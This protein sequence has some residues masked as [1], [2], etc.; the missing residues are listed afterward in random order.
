[1][2]NNQDISQDNYPI[3]QLRGK[4][5]GMIFQEPMTSL[6]PL[7]TI[8]KQISEAIII[9]NPDED[10]NSKIKEL[11]SM[12]EL[13]Y[14]EERINSFPH[15]LSGGERQRVMLA[16][17]IANKPKLLIADEP[18]TA[19]DP[20]TQK[21]ILAL[22]NKLRRQF[23]MSVLL[24]SH[25]I[26]LVKQ[27]SDYIYIIFQGKIIEHNKSYNIFNDPQNDYTKLLINPFKTTRNENKNS[28]SQDL[29]KISNL[30]I[31]LSNTKSFL[32]KNYKTI[33]H[34]INLTLN[35]SDILGIIGKSGS[36]KTTL[37]NSI[38]GLNKGSGEII[39][40]NQNILKNRNH[41]GKIQIVFQD[42]YSSL[43]PKMTIKEIIIE[44]L[45]INKKK[46]EIN[47]IYDTLKMVDLNLEILDKYPHALSG[48]QKQRV[49]IARAIITEPEILI[50]DEATSSLDQITQ[51]SII[52]LLNKL[53]Q[54]KNISMIFITHNIDLLSRLCNKVIVM[55]K[56][57]IIEYGNTAEII[58]NPQQEYSKNLIHY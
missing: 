56:G 47:I 35:K 48:G 16:I 45:S 31:S 11:L 38:L 22:I 23:N 7:H 15:E 39:F 20:L 14:L 36:G 19:L 54:E 41:K 21:K 40:N 55:Q 29:L 53:N 8:H 26:K 50:L 49:A 58:K 2:L 44:S 43:N 10:I 28:D 24:I 6:N 25:D 30:N 17:A 51:E 52:T 5:I 27:I 42:P 57:K 3:N 4:D 37:I 9:H 32:F 12:V 13:E 46:Y 1:L 18:T 34:D 33:L